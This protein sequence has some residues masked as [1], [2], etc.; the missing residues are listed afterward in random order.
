MR[1]RRGGLRTKKGR[2]AGRQGKYEL[3][4][5]FLSRV[6]AAMCCHP[7]HHMRLTGASRPLEEAKKQ[8]KEME[9]NDEQAA[10]G[11]RARSPP[12]HTVAAVSHRL[13]GREEQR[14][15]EERLGVMLADV[16]F[17]VKDVY[18]A[19]S[20]ISGKGYADK[21]VTRNISRLHLTRW[22]KRKGSVV[23]NLVLM[24]VRSL[25]AQGGGRS[26]TTWF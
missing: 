21:G 18:R 11:S 4:N 13:E 17:L 5:L 7:F 23:D 10:F 9:K 22:D 2:E 19:R 3:A 15:G 8:R 25:G 1:R 6:Q 26:W 20:A 16:E 14:H 12:L 24:E